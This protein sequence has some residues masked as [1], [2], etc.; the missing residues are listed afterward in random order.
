MAFAR[1]GAELIDGYSEQRP[2]PRKTLRP[3]K[4][5]GVE[6][7]GMICSEL[8]LGLSEE[9]EGVLLLPPDLPVGAPLRT[10]LGDEV[11][12]L[13]LTPDMARCLQR[14]RRR[15]GSQRPDRERPS[16]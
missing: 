11:L 13:E 14:D 16:A 10:C 15:Q 3:A 4:I 6:S 1:E 2:R 5:R 8:E 7:K 12:N 9:H